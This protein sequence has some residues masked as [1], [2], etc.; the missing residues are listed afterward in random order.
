MYILDIYI[1]H[2]HVAR[3]VVEK[4]VGGE[5][6][7]FLVTDIFLKFTFINWNEFWTIF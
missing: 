4:G 5:T 7:P 1:R 3:R 2:K 6:V